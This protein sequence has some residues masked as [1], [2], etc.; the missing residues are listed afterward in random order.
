MRCC[1][2]GFPTGILINPICAC[3]M[4]IL[5][6]PVMVSTGNTHGTGCTLSAA[7][8]AHLDTDTGCPACSKQKQAG[9]GQ[10]GNAQAF[11]PMITRRNTIFQQIGTTCLRASAMIS[12]I[13]SGRNF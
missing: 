5:V 3:L 2:R 4:S 11:L 8:A 6:D 1:G 12:A 13:E 9:C 10:S 7:I